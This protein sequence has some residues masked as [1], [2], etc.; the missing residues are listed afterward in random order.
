MDDGEEKKED[1]VCFPSSKS[2]LSIIWYNGCIV[3]DLMR[4]EDDK[5]KK[6]KKKKSETQA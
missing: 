2:F 6:R 4:R 1:N 3:D 5:K